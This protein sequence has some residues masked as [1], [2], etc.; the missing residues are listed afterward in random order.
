MHVGNGNLVNASGFSSRSLLY[1][2]APLHVRG[3]YRKPQPRGQPGRGTSVYGKST[4]GRIVRGRETRLQEREVLPS[5]M[6]PRS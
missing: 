2:A 1:F 4:H 3:Q 5:L 6:R